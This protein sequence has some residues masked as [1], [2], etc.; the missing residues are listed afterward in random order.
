MR[1]RGF[2]WRAM[3]DSCRRV[4]RL[5]L[6]RHA[7]SSWEDT[8]ARDFDRTLNARG[9]KGAAL[10]GRHIVE[11]GIRWEHVLASPAARVRETLAAAIE[12]AGR[13]PPITWDERIYMAGPITLLE[14]LREAPED[15][16]SIVLAGHNPGLHEL[17]FELVAD[18]DSPLLDEI[19]GKY[20]T[21]AFAVL[22]FDIDSWQELAPHCGKLVHFARPRDLD[23]RLGPEMAD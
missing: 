19:A 22:E 9:R 8:G 21:A 16:D 2:P 18:G 6:F 14:V 20:P 23:S 5:G 15:C 12:A 7:K 1:R 13:S 3:K 4:K 10:M 17:L 11:H